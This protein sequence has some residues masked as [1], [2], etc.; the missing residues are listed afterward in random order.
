[1]RALLIALGLVVL[2]CRDPVGSE[3]TLRVST[4]A[5]VFARGENGV[6][7]QV[8]FTVLNLGA[9]PVLVARCGDRLVA[10]L[11]RREGL[12]WTQ[13]SGDYCLAVFPMDPALMQPGEERSEMRSIT[14][15]GTY[16]LRIGR[17]INNGETRWD[18][19]SN[20]FEIR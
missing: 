13:Y 6:A 18:V 19:T 11:D 8:A 10:A 12:L 14:E 16:R 5:P 4:S 17:E 7:A 2:G 15:V 20:V 1:M 3:P 9:Q